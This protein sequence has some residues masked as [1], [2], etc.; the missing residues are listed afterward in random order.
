MCLFSSGFGLDGNG[1]ALGSDASL[2]YEFD[3][4]NSSVECLRT[5]ISIE[6]SD[7]IDLPLDIIKGA[8]S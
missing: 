7:K 1:L 4:T 5:L 2:A 3:S 6:L 8:M